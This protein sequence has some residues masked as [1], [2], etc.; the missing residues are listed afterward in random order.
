MVFIEKHMQ[1][2]GDIIYEEGMEVGT[3]KVKENMNWKTLRNVSDVRFFMGI[4]SYYRIF[5]EGFSKISY[6]IT[7]LLKK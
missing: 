3:N 4:S 1:Y 2:L 7:S 5:I 6:T